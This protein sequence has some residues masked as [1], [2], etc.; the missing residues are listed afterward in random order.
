MSEGVDAAASTG[1]ALDFL[2]FTFEIAFEV[3]EEGNFFLQFLG[4]VIEGVFG[5]LIN[6]I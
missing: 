1:G 6:L 3:E 4:V 2:L 5:G